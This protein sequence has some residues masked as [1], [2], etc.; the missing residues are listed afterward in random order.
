M[1]TL[2]LYLRSN[3]H[4]LQWSANSFDTFFSLFNAKTGYDR[5]DTT[6]SLDNSPWGLSRSGVG[7][8]NFRLRTPLVHT[9]CFYWIQ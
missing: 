7:V 5:L 2:I 9:N 6:K 4:V 1:A 8:K 3:W